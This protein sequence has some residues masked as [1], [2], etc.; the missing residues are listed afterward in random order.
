MHAIKDYYDMAAILDQYPQI[1]MNFNLVPSLLMQIED[2]IAGGAKDEFWTITEKE[3]VSLSEEDKVFLLENFFFANWST[4]VDVYPRY[5]QLLDIRGR[6]ILEDNLSKIVKT[7]PSSYFLDLQ[8]WFNLSWVDPIFKE[9]DEFIASLLQKGENFTEEEK[10]KLLDKHL[11][12]MGMII[13]KYKEL[14]EKGQI[15]I[16]TSP[17]YHPILPL[18][19]N[20]SI[21][22]KSSPH[23]H[24]PKTIFLHESDAKIQISRAIKYFEKTFGKK[25]LGMWP[26]EGGVS[27]H[28]LDIIASCGL[29]WIATDED[30]LFHSLKNEHH[31]KDLYNAYKFKDK[32][33]GIV[34]RDKKLSD[35]IGFS[36]SNMDADVAKEMINRLAFSLD[37]LHM[38][39][40]A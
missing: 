1:K 6:D 2:Y 27:D 39:Y 19:I 3:A 18:L 36:Y 16:C 12:I 8:V 38:Q 7:L 33:L 24:S 32:D 25:P 34:F 26:S 13:P 21:S 15:E 29:K 20:S 23:K 9:R 11:E 31:R 30:I 40:K 17:F 14:M 22:R 35:L 37:L 4:M 5:K 28:T 10:I